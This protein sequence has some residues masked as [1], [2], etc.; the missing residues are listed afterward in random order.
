MKLKKT[1]LV[2]LFQLFLFSTYGQW[3][4]TL[5]NGSLK[6]LADKDYTSAYSKL[7]LLVQKA[8]YAPEVFYN[9]GVL[10]FRTGDAEQ[11]CL[12]IRLAKEMKLKKAVVPVICD[13]K[14]L[15]KSLNE[16][17]YKGVKLDSALDYRPHYTLKDTL[18]GKLRAERTCFDVTFYNLTVRIIPFGKK[19]KGHNIIDFKIV[20]PTHRIQ[21][22]LF[23]NLFIDSI[24]WNHHA[25]KYSRI[26]DAVFVEF[27][28]TL[29]KGTQQ[30][31]TFYYHGQPRRAV[32]APWDGGFDWKRERIL[33]HWVGVACEQ[34]GASCW[35]PNKDHL[36]DEPDSMQ[37]HLE[38]PKAYQ[39]ISNGT[40]QSV[41]KAHGGYARYNWTVHYPINN[42]NVTFYMGKF[43]HFT[44]TLNAG[45]QVVKMEYYVLPQ[46]LKK[47]QDYFKQTKDIV[48][49]YNDL[50]G[51]YPFIKDKFCLV[52][53]SYAGMEHQNC[54]AYGNDYGKDKSRE[55]L[56]GY[57]Q[58]IVHEAAHEWWGNSV[59]CGDM[60]EA[61]IHEAF[62]TYAEL[63]FLE[64][65]VG[66][67][68]GYLPL[69][70][71]YRDQIVNFWPMVH[72]FDVNEYSFASNDI[73]MKG[74]ALLDN[75]RCTIDNDSIFFS[76]L[77]D[78]QLKYKY[79][80]VRSQD[81]VDMVNSYT[82]DDYTAFFK[83]F[84][85][86]AKLPVLRYKFSKTDNNI[87][88]TCRWENVDPGFKMPFCIRLDK[89]RSIRIM[90][91][92]TD[93]SIVLENTST[94]N[95]FTQ[96]VGFKGCLK[97]CYTY[98]WTRKTEQP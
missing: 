5:W 22:D 96:Y 11:G 1:W 46:H 84:L 56:E 2:F 71:R 62:A 12:N 14:E 95:F 28:E 93:Q 80:V 97:N 76:I 48:R 92:D 83:K 40:L 85:Y 53:S 7:D 43:K 38:V 45:S 4:T 91:T 67:E 61:W 73:Y 55:S 77:K 35:W 70:R 39:A 88:L 6:D 37:I 18:R 86:D 49:I 50:F 32:K 72:H 59:S 54:I 13:K 42:Y 68:R 31:L 89:D 74:A 63:L 82:H 52:E 75:L 16:F 81:F 30:Q 19:I 47:A 15:I 24:V 20:E 9:R 44:D 69:L 27:P 26:Y 3:D 51:V 60:A 94:F 98:Y 78:F 79:Q 10:M 17:F 57:D 64:K 58:L 21:L 23:S 34:L 66:Y 41:E 90:A 29:E 65:T 36:T 8:P 33:N 25:L 87:E